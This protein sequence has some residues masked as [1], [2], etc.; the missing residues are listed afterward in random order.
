MQVSVRI[1]G[2]AALAAALGTAGPRL[3]QRTT[4]AVHQFAVLLVER[5]QTA[6]SGRPGPNIVTGNLYG[7][8]LIDHTLGDTDG[9][10]V[11][12]VYTST[13]YARRL[14]LGF[15]GTDSLG[16]SYSQPPYPFFSRAVEGSVDEFI[17]VM[18]RAVNGV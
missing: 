13:I 1:Q 6:A 16:R 12:T 3:K 8:I 11:A 9:W 18:Q 4:A 7:S 5:I 15:Y 10:G 2:D 14:E 17:S